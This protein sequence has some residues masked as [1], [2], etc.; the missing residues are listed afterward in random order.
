MNRGNLLF[1]RRNRIEKF[2]SK[3]T[4]ISVPKRR[5]NGS[6][7]N[8]FMII[9][10]LCGFILIWNKVYIS[11]NEFYE[12]NL[13]PFQIHLIDNISGVTPEQNLYLFRNGIEGLYDCFLNLGRIVRSKKG[14]PVHIMEVGMH[15][16]RQCIT[17]ANLG[18]EA[19]CI[20]PSPLSVPRIMRAISKADVNIQER[21]RFYQMAAGATT[22][23]TLKFTSSGGT[24][25]HI[26]GGID[27]WNMIR[28]P[29]ASASTN[30]VT[31]VKSISIDDIVFNNINPTTTFGSR[32]KNDDNGV[33]DHHLYMLKIDTQGFEPLVFSG[34][35]RAIQERRI[36]FIITEFWP[37]GMDLMMS[38]S[39][40]ESGAVEILKTLH[41]AGYTL[42]STRVIQHPKGPIEPRKCIRD[43]IECIRP[44]DDAKK[45][46][47]WF[48]DIEK[49]FPHDEYKMGYWSDIVA[50]SPSA[51]IPEYDP[52]IEKCGTKS[53]A[54]DI[55]TRFRQR[56]DWH[57]N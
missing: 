33:I 10:I 22:G 35:K 3:G 28:L 11:F 24:G 52:S 6:I 36:D 17:A 7:L 5:R 53:N 47:M 39:A 45:F 34:L 29:E 44:T 16:A 51:E 27:V 55:I 37:K 4:F 48:Y 25:D 54:K 41:N 42:Y 21:I 43:D 56:S 57:N 18:L 46:C 8:Y 20:E 26:G 12:I 1:K 23:E 40:C 19:H 9:S 13:E 2:P 49:M 31:D 38:T 15:S 30:E 14:N 32:I 50:V